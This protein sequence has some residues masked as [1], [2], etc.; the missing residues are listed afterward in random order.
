VG[1]V[2]GVTFCPECVQSLHDA[3]KHFWV[4]DAHSRLLLLLRLLLRHFQ[5]VGVKFP[6]S[7]N[8]DF[9]IAG[10]LKVR[11]YVTRIPKHLRRV[12]Q[13]FFIS[14]IVGNSLLGY[15]LTLY[16]SNGEGSITVES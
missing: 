8:L 2:F 5:F 14:V 4:E 6:T 16:P 1:G 9:L 7:Y 15:L 11:N 12:Q 3:I 10:Q 13:R